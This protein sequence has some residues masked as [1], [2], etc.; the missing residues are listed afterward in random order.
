[1]QHDDFRRWARRAADRSADW[2]DL[3]RVRPADVIDAR[4]TIT[5]HAATGAR[6]PEAGRSPPPGPEGGRH[7]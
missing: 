3:S 4:E 6:G 1:M 5:A 7:D 2:L